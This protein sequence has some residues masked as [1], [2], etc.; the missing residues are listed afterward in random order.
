M[1]GAAI[2][3]GAGGLL[4]L[5]Q[6]NQEKGQYNRDKQLA[7]DMERNSPWT[8]IHGQMPKSPTGAFGS[9]LQGATSGAMMGAPGG[10]FGGAKDPSALVKAQTNYYNSLV[11]QAPAAPNPMQGATPMSSGPS[12]FY[13]ERNPSSWGFGNIS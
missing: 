7:A 11:P 2:G 1:A 8:G 5:V 6:S 4:G 13:N 12:T 3:A 9:A 10:L